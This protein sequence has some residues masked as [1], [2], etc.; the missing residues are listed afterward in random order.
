MTWRPKQLAGAE[1][2]P[3]APPL[4]PRAI[5]GGPDVVSHHS[6]N[7]YRGSASPFKTERSF[8]S[9]QGAGLPG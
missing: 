7:M 2:L 4:D 5:A 8:L 3:V 1:G 9:S 6:D